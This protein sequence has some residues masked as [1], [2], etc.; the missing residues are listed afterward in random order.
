VKPVEAAIEEAK[1][2]INEGG[3]ARLRSARESLERSLHAAA[4]ELYRSAGA[5]AGAEGQTGA[6]SP[7]AEAGPGPGP[8]S[9]PSSD[10][11]QPGK[12]AQGDVIDAEY[13]DVDETKRPN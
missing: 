7:G 8:G 4:E 11:D 10:Q 13:V 6:P 12:K 3:T 5:A 1:K 2:A 9:G